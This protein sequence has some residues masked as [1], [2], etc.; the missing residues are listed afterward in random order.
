VAININSYRELF[1]NIRLRPGMWLIR[2]DF[3]CVVAFVDGCNEANA[4]TLFTGFHEW[5]VTRAGRG[6]NHTWW[7]LIQDLTEPV[8][9]KYI[10]TMP[11]DLDAR[12][13]AT[14]FDMLDEFLE[15]REERDGLRRIFA[16]YEHWR[17]AQDE[18]GCLTAE[19]APTTEWPRAASRRTP[20]PATDQTA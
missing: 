4:R 6:D 18:D 5:L 16:A 17:R 7:S 14:L 2:P 20:T 8:G 13:V 9:P 11:A 10:S 12:M 19:T 3:A 15:L 1:T